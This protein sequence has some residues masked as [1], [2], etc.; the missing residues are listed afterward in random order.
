MIES[1]NGVWWGRTIEY[2]MLVNRRSHS[3]GVWHQNNRESWT[4]GRLLYLWAE[5]GVPVEAP[6]EE[7]AVLH[8]GE[9]ALALEPDTTGPRHD[10][11]LHVLRIVAQVGRV[12]G[13]RA[14]LCKRQKRNTWERHQLRELKLHYFNKRKEM[15]GGRWWIILVISL[16][17]A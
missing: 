2:N 1:C 6:I 5:A 11:A 17:E 3:Q 7:G 12:H 8:R 9:D 14:D 13:L 10:L 4:K 15:G 16:L